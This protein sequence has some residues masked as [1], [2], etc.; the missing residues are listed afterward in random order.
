MFDEID[1]AYFRLRAEDEREKAAN[2]YDD[3]ALRHRRRAEAFEEKA[4]ILVGEATS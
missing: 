1:A 4:R 2:A 3:A